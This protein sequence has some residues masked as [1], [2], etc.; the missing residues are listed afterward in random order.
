MLKNFIYLG[1][2]AL[3]FIAC[4]N[5]PAD[6]TEATGQPQSFGK[7]ISAD[8]AVTFAELA[9]KLA[10]VDSMQVKVKGTVQEVCQ[11]KGCWMTLNDAQASQELFVQFKD[12]G[13]FMPKDIHGR[14]VIIDGIAYREVTSVADLK[15]YAEDEGLSKEVIDTIVTP[16]EELK[17]MANGV[18]LLP[19][20]SGK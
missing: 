3:F 14:E 17:F 2:F 18:L 11:K 8:N 16:K 6:T 9:P 15:H 1:A 7:L 13:F 4:Q 20:P 19:T 10:G 5:P 12:Y